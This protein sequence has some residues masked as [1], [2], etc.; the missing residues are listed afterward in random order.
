MIQ[1]VAAVGVVDQQA[2][3]LAPVRSTDSGLGGSP[4]RT[5]SLAAPSCQGTNG[6]ELFVGKLF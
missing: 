2:D 5:I 1:L 4:Q 3:F 6:P